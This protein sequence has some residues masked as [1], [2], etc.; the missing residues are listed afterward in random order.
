MVGPITKLFGWLLYFINKHT[1]SETIK[2]KQCKGVMTSR[3]QYLA[4]LPVFFDEE[5]EESAAYYLNN[6]ITIEDEEEIPTGRRA[7]YIHVFQ[8]GSCANKLISVVDFLKV[9]EQFLIKG[10]DTYPYEEF[11]TY[12]E[13]RS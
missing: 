3:K 4:L 13:S 8:C 9:R 12:I 1:D 11:R 10:G 2:C 7:C 5:H 6:M